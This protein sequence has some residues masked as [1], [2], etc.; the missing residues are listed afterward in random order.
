MKQK[1]GSIREW[2]GAYADKELDQARADQ[3]VRHLETCADCRRELDQIL[4]LSRLAK[5]VEHPRLADDYWDWQRTRVW[6]GLRERRR[7]PMP[8][9]RPSF[10]WPK[11]AAAAAGFVIVLVVVLAGWRT[12]LQRPGTVGRA[13]S[14]PKTTSEAPV[15]AAPVARRSAESDEAEKAAGGTF[16]KAEG[17]SDEFARVPATAVR[18]AEKAK[19]GYAAKGAGRTAGTAVAAKPATAPVRRSAPEME[20]A[21]EEFREELSAAPSASGQHVRVSSDKQKGR[22]VSG[23]VLLESPPLPD[24]DALDTGTVLLRVR[25]DSAGRVL[26]AAVRRSSGSSK[27]DSVAV[28]Q[29]RGSRFKAAVR[30]NRSVASSFEYPF[31]VQKRQTRSVEMEKPTVEEAKPDKRERRQEGKRPDRQPD[32]Q[33]GNHSGKKEARQPDKQSDKQE[34]NHSDEQ[35]VRQPD[36]QSD[37]QEDTQPDSQPNRPPKEKTKK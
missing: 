37:K 28:R 1:C 16:A 33:K 10:V 32:T 20:V 7:A 14:E 9:Y 5:G 4:E 15:A 34:D 19:V 27:L 29:I 13:L 12:L 22:I 25:T 24:A 8:S 18:D 17:R 35:E 26:N 6:R 21:A 2:L 30:N 3:V 31:R 23:P 36:K 11:L